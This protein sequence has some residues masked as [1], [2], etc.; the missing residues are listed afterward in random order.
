MRTPHDKQIIEHWLRLYN[1]LTGA[2]YRVTAWPDSDSSKQNVD[3]LCTNSS[4][5]T[6]TIEHTLI[7]PFQNEKADTVR[8][9]QT[10]AALENDPALCLE[11]YTCMASQRVGAI[12]N[13]VRW[14][15]FLASLKSQ[16][17]VAIP[18]LPEGRSDVF[19]SIGTSSIKMSVNKMRTQFD[20]MGQFLTARQYPGPVGSELNKKRFRTQT[21]Q[22]CCVSG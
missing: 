14:T 18:K 8:F 11:G 13:G 4:G 15:D 1:R 2:S 7:E 16:L 21:S 5:V 6:L 10:L 17:A 20:E 12:P 22:T 9:M 19:V 3:A